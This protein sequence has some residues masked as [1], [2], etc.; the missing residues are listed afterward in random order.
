MDDHEHELHHEYIRDRIKAEQARREFWI[1]LA[2]KTLPSILGTLLL[3]LFTWIYHN[4][5]I[6]VK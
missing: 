5:S 6:G 2:Q 1:G 3:G 4:I